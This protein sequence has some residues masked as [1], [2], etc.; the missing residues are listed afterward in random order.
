M[1]IRLTAVNDHITEKDKEIFEKFKFEFEDMKEDRYWNWKYKITNA[2]ILEIKSLKELKDLFN[3]VGDLIISEA[4][5]E[6]HELNLMIYNGYV[7]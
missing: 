3:E 6:S 7:E 1:K 4:H 5:D 2:P